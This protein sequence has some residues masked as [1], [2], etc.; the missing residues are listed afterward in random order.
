MLELNIMRKFFCASAEHM[1]H[2]SGVFDVISKI[3]E[4]CWTV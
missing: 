3:A 2:D 4:I 1:K